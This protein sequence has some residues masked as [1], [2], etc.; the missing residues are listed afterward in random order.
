MKKTAI[1]KLSAVALALVLLVAGVVGI[2]AAATD[3]ETS[4]ELKIVTLN[5]GAELRLAYAYELTGVEPD[6]VEI[7]VYKDE[8]LEGAYTTSQFSESYYS[9]SY[10]V[11]YSSGVSA[12]DIADTLYAVPVLK[13]TGE[14]IG[15][16]N[17]Y[18]VLKYCYDVIYN[19][20]SSSDLVLLAKEL[21][22][23]G[24]AAQ[25]RLINIGNIESETLVTDYV[26]LYTNAEGVTVNGKRSVLV[27]SGDTV[28]VASESYTSYKVVSEGGKVSYIYGGEASFVAS[29]NAKVELDLVERFEAEDPNIYFDGSNSANV[30]LSNDNA[31]AEFG[32]VADPKNAANNVLRVRNTK[33]TAG[34]QNHTYIYVNPAN[35]L[36][37]GNCVCFTTSVYFEEFSNSGDAIVKLFL[38]SNVTDKVTY[39]VKSVYNANTTATLSGPT[40]VIATVVPGVWYD[41]RIEAYTLYP[42]T[43]VQV[44]V[45]EKGDELALVEEYLINEAFEVTQAYFKQFGAKTTGATLIDDVILE[46]ID[47][48]LTSENIYIPDP[49][50]AEGFEQGL[51]TTDK[52]TTSGSSDITEL[53]VTKDPDNADN[54]VLKVSGVTGTSSSS[55][56]TTLALSNPDAEGNCY[57]FEGRFYFEDLDSDEANDEIQ[58]SFY[59]GTARFATVGFAQSKDGAVVYLKERNGGTEGTGSKVSLALDGTDLTFA[60][61]GWYTVRYELYMTGNAETCYTKVYIGSDGLQPVC[62]AEFIGYYSSEVTSFTSLDSVKLVWQKYNTQYTLY[63][64]DLSFYKI[65]KEFTSSAN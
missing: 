35:D 46:G 18:S 54:S 4:A 1:L 62:V 61:E 11:Y 25:Q 44:Y 24:A 37:A 10:P 21:I 58:I 29:E 26:Y 17:A 12:K 56:T 27:K 45:G 7:R 14:A 20:N 5:Y 60:S 16:A 13:S 38:R 34:S 53:E 9:E 19:E 47:K 57:V 23:Y 2:T 64:D 52:I 28:T 3:G 41:I 59:N 40:G 50:I 6:K 36:Y 30:Y 42:Y 43:A 33:V 63:A 8:A 48:T 22:E 55:I 15:D 31:N 49:E 65:S 32:V 51:T 39:T